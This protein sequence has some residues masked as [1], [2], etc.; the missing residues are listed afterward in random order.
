MVDHHD[1]H[2]LNQSWV[3]AMSCRLSF[4]LSPNWDKEKHGTKVLSKMSSR[5][6]ICGL[7]STHKMSKQDLIQKQFFKCQILTLL[8]WD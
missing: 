8:V 3:H 4:A 2:Y 7:Q 6:H 5:V 1:S